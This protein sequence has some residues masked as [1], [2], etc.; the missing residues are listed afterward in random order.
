M[1]YYGE[2]PIPIPSSNFKLVILMECSFS[3]PAKYQIGK[4]ELDS[5]LYIF[6]PSLFII[7]HGSEPSVIISRQLSQKISLW[8]L[9]S[10]PF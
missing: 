7:I 2:P 4:G 3:L 6:L 1:Q 5:I 10:I 8:I 9:D